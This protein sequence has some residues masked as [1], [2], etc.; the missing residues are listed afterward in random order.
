MDIS[1]KYLPGDA[2]AIANPEQITIIIHCCNN[3][4]KWGLGFVLALSK[5]WPKIREEYLKQ[6]M[7]LGSVAIVQVEPK[8]YIANIIGQDGYG[9]SQKKY[10]KYKALRS[11][12]NSILQFITEYKGSEKIV[13]QGPQ[14][15]SGLAGGNWTKIAALLQEIFCNNDVEVTIYTFHK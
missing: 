7:T 15:G 11:G 2:T 5:K 8:V 4:R 1:V 13:I 12:F 9:T 10:V 14:L 6:T 3:K